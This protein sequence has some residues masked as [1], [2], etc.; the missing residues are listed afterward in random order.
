ME[1]TSSLQKKRGRGASK[2]LAVKE[3]MFLEYNEQNIPTGKWK[4]QYG[5][6]LGL[7]ASR[8]SINIRHFKDVE[9]S[10]TDCLWE[11]TKVSFLAIRFESP[12]IVF[13]I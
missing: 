4:K 13:V 12:L 9:E 10:E 1:G 3:P 5:I 8:I 6:H 11:D 7:C 2:N